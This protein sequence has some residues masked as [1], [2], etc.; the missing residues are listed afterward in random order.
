MKAFSIVTITTILLALTGCGSDDFEGQYVTEPAD[1]GSFSS[2]TQQKLSFRSDGKVS[3]FLGGNKVG[4]YKYEKNGDEITLFKGDGTTQM[5]TIEGDGSLFG[6]GAEFIRSSSKSIEEEEADKEAADKK[7]VDKKAADK[8]AADKLGQSV[9]G[10]HYIP[11]PDP[12]MNLRGERLTKLIFGV[13][14]KAI[15]SGKSYER[16]ELI[17]REEVMEYKI[18]GNKITLVDGF[19]DSVFTIG[20]NGSLFDGDELVFVKN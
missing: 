3:I 17:D 7:V 6:G 14:G 18:A 13:D 19:G 5:L 9:I 8:G 1:E 20:E 4:V 15:L 11:A 2:M 12:N 16:G 10:V